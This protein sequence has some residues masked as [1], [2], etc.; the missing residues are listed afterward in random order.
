LVEKKDNL[1]KKIAKKKRENK[2]YKLIVKNIEYFNLLQKK[3][4]K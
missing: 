1:G 3:K 4:R 2:E